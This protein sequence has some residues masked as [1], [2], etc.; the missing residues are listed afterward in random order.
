LPRESGERGRTHRAHAR[1]GNRGAHAARHGG[2]HPDWPRDRRLAG[3]RQHRSGRAGWP[4]ACR[5][6]RRAFVST[7]TKATFMSTATAFDLFAAAPWR[8]APILA[9]DVRFPPGCLHP[10]ESSLLTV[11]ARD[12]FVGAG[13]IVDAGAF[14]GRS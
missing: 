3:R 11:L 14:L 8:E 13:A 6:G 9:N 10:R 1:S 12:Y 2:P 5:C 7:T 4:D